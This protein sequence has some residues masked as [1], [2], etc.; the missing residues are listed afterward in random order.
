MAGSPKSSAANP[1]SDVKD[2]DSHYD[3]ALWASE[4]GIINGS[5]F[6][7]QTALTRGEFVISL[8][9][10]LGCPE[11]IQVNQYLDIDS[12]HSDFGRALAWSH[13]NGIMGATEQN[14]FSPKK[15]ISK[16][17]VINIMYRALK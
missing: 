8:W 13:V 17:D 2:T 9:K 11:G 5:S 3:A 10:Y 15:T 12:H 16:A 14:K 7:P 4:K 1:F 6:A